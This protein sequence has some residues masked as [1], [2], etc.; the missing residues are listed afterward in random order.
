MSEKDLSAI[1]PNPLIGKRIGVFEVKKEIGR[2]GMG[3]VYLAERVDGEFN[4]TVAIKLIKRGMDT[5]LVLKRFRRERQILAA[6]DHP[7]IAYFL[8]GDSTEDG[9][10][11]FVME[12]IEGKPLYQFCDENK[13]SINERLKI[14]QQVCSAVHAAHRIQ[15]IHRDLKPSNILVKANKVPKLLDFGIAKVLDP[16]LAV[17]QIDPTSTQMRVMTPEYA[18]PEQ[19][20]GDDVTP[21]SDIYSL[22]VLLYE[23]LTGHRPYRL[24]RRAPFEIARVICEEMPSIPSGSLTGEDN[25]VPTKEN[26]KVSLEFILQS[27]RATLETLK[28]QLSGDLDKIVLKALRKNPSERYQS[29]QEL[30]DDIANYLAGRAVKAE[31]FPDT[32][33]PQNEKSSVAILPFKVLGTADSDEEFLGLGL[34]D[35]LVMRLSGMQRLVVRP[36][37]SVMRF[38]ESEPFE[39]GRELGV[40]YIVDGNIRRAGERIRVTV[41]LLNVGENAAQW[42]EKFDEKSADVLELEDSIS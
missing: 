23:L 6:L 34:T 19:I 41:Q 8:S 10:P 40:K 37:S 22:G 14:F 25:L 29:A 16:E 38:A 4:Q 35:A 13:L 28:N 17:T 1:S 32:I 36:T 20:I 33:E 18:S 3:T 5:D 9:L 26:G 2:G 11:Y 12:Y 31:Y 21:A 24:K 39:A 30:A 15:V 42:A 7:N 27:R